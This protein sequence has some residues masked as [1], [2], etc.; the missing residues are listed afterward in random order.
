ML[1]GLKWPPAAFASSAQLAP[2]WMWKP[3]TPGGTLVRSTT[4]WVPSGRSVKVTVP[5]AVWP[6]VGDNVAVAV[7]PFAVDPHA[8]AIREMK[9]MTAIFLMAPPTKPYHHHCDHAAIRFPIAP[10]HDVARLW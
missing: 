4:T 7:G 3:C 10:S 9:E 2:S 6:V 8:S 5:F 1:S